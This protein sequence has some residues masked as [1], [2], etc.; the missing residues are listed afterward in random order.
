MGVSQ[1]GESEFSPLGRRPR[2]FPEQAKFIWEK[3]PGR[4]PG[5]FY[6]LTGNGAHCRASLS[7]LRE[8]LG[9]GWLLM[10]RSFSPKYLS[11]KL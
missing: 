8:R 9:E 11:E 2:G 6:Y 7:R 4:K 5:D 1:G 10:A 3:Y